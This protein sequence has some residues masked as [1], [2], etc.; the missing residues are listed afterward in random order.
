MNGINP[1]AISLEKKLQ[2]RN[3]L[4]L[5]EGNFGDHKFCREGVWELK[6]HASA[7]YR[8]YYS[9][10]GN[11]IILLLCGGSKNSQQQDIQKATEYL[12]KYKEEHK[13]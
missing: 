12:K 3:I 9:I 10:S 7:G 11:K 6:I 4:H 5:E 13:W 1:C 2:D 8:V